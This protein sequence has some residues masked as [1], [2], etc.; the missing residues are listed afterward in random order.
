MNK[1][2]LKLA[3]E[4][5]RTAKELTAKTSELQEVKNVMPQAEAKMRDYITKIEETERK[6]SREYQEAVRSI[7]N[8]TRELLE[9]IN[10]SVG[11]YLKNAGY[12]VRKVEN[13]G[14]RL[15]V[16]VGSN[17]G[18]ERS[19]SRVS[20]HISQSGDEKKQ[21]YALHNE[22]RTV[23]GELNTVNTV[24]NLIEEIRNLDKRGFW[25]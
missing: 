12:G 2:N 10:S 4:L 24:S 22:D 3:G 16:Y 13:D 18:T 20:I 6:L 5:V 25:K 21:S 7:R 19:V 8:K 1:G 15:E 23:E 9:S 17:D 14:E 11:D